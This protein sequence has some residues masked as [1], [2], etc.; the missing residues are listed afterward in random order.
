MYVLGLLLFPS[1]RFAYHKS[2][3]VALGVSSVVSFQ[4]GA[5]IA[6]GLLF[7][8]DLVIEFTTTAVGLGPSMMALIMQPDM[9]MREE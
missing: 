4:F 5:F 8:R 7:C 1:R 2:L 6:K 3:P 9:R